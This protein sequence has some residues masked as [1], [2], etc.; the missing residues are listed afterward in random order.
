MILTNIYQKIY[1]N[2]W[3]NLDKPLFFIIILLFLL[4]LFLSL[5]IPILIEKSPLISIV[6]VSGNQSSNT[7]QLS[8][9][10]NTHWFS[11]LITALICL[12]AEMILI[13]IK[14]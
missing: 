12:F 2:W 13:R 9:L 3:R 14:I 7:A 6:E 8:K 1:F 11:C 4:G 5:T 10:K